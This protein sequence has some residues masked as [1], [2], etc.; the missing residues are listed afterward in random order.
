MAMVMP[1]AAPPLCTRSALKGTEA[2]PVCSRRCVAQGWRRPCLAQLHAR[3]SH[4]GPAPLCCAGLQTAEQAAPA[5]RAPAKQ[6]AGKP[7]GG[8]KGG[9]GQSGKKGGG[10][11]GG[12]GEKRVTPKSEDFSRY[13]VPLPPPSPPLRLCTGC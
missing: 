10:G 2:A 8:G 9:G 3:A 11:G 1:A 12:S 13:G 5:E 7:K 4:R 6:A